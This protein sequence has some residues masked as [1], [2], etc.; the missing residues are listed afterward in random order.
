MSGRKLVDQLRGC[1]LLFFREIEYSRPIGRTDVITLPIAGRGVMYL[2]KEFQQLPVGSFGRVEFNEDRF[3]MRAMIPI[4]G[5]WNV[6][7]C[8]PNVRLKDT[9]LAAD[10]FLYAPEAT[11]GKDSFFC[12]HK[13]C[14]VFMLREACQGLFVT[15]RHPW[16]IK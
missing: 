8:V 3:S 9:R 16:M 12:I 13:C 11:A 15:F 2:E 5:V 10:Q 14:I 7:S 6:S 4:G 1:I